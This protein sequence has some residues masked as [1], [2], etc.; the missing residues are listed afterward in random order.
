MKTMRYC[1][2]LSVM[3]LCIN[4]KSQM[5]ELWGTTMVGGANATFTNTG[6]TLYKINGDGTGFQ[7]LHAFS[8][9]ATPL[10]AL[11][12]TPDGKIYGTTF[13]SKVAYCYNPA[14]G[15]FSD[16]H[17]FTGGTGGSNISGDLYQ[18]SNGRLYGVT[19]SGGTSGYGILYSMDSAGLQFQKHHDF[20][21]Y[22]SPSHGFVEDNTGKLWA[23]TPGGGIYGKGT[24]YYF[25]PSSASYKKVFSF[26]DT[27][28][29]FP[30]GKLLKATNNL[31][32]G[33]AF[34]GGTDSSGCIFSFDPASGTFNQLYSF[35]G[36][37]FHGK[38]YPAWGTGTLVQLNDSIMVGAL[39]SAGID[40]AGIIFS[41][42]INSNVYQQHFQFN[43]SNGRFPWGG[44]AV[45]KDGNI[46]GVTRNG[47]NNGCGTIYRFN[48][49]S[50]SFTSIFSFDTSTTG[51]Y[52][53]SEL[54][55]YSNSFS[56]IYP[57]EQ[58][59]S[60][61]PNPVK[62]VLQIQLGSEA[63]GE[64]FVIYD[65]L[66]KPVISSTVPGNLATVNTQSLPVGQYI[67]KLKVANN[68]Y[69]F[70]SFVKQ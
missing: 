48:L 6:G 40:S 7:V 11:L 46:Y 57:V 34:A 24:L 60:I 9:L 55:V 3:C 51:G 39:G 70:K 13:N 49:P 68:N 66:G 23:T 30:S 56:S 35:S 41:Y 47:G 38:D 21:M 50:D 37:F 61:Y 17:Q 16:I 19:F 20:E 65:A 25:E 5:V 22:S 52:P 4:L 63:V 31:F 69:V 44:L 12:Q 2:L 58:S 8:G 36:V 33:V 29:A 1:L 26:N 28:G 42:N 32:Y 15:G 43:G 54:L 53:H 64:S 62:D 67:L 10:G 45:A 59:F 14:T 18:Y 27:L